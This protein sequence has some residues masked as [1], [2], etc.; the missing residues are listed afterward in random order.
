MMQ[1][2]RIAKWM[3]QTPLRL[4]LLTTKLLSYPSL[5]AS[6]ST[7]DLCVCVSTTHNIVGL[8]CF[9]RS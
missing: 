5:L 2:G 8:N 9:T 4:E 1:N 7:R 6:P 3:Y